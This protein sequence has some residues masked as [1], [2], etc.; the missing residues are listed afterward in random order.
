MAKLDEF[1]LSNKQ[2]KEIDAD[3]ADGKISH[4][5]ISEKLG[6]W[7]FDWSE[8]SVRR[9]RN[10]LGVK[11]ES[12]ESNFDIPP[13][14]DWEKA[15]IEVGPD[16]GVISTGVLN[17][18]ISL[19]ND[20]DGV[21]RGFGLDPELFEVA[22]DTVRMSKWQSSKRLDNGDRDIVWLYSY[23]AQFR[24]KS[25]QF[26]APD[27][28]FIHKQI[29]KWK[30][31]KKIQSK[32]IEEPCTFLIN[33]A[34]WQIGKSAGG[35]VEATVAKIEESF[36]L[37]LN[38]IDR[39][40]K[41][42]RNIESVAIFNM[43][44][45]TEGC[46]G[47]YSSQLFTVELNQR[48]QL[49]LVL[50]LW[51]K[52]LMTLQPDVF[53]SVLCNHGEW[54]RRGGSKPVTS[55]SDNAGGYLADTLYRVFE[56]KQGPSEWHIAHDEMIQMVNLSGI[57][58]AM[59]HGHK[60]TSK[61]KEAE[62]LRGQSIRLLKTHGVEPDVWFT[63]HL[64]HVS[65]EDHGPWWR[66][67]CPSLDGGSKWYTDFSGNWSTPGTLT[68]LIGKHDVRGWSDMSVLGTHEGHF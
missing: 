9:Y 34:D 62:W 24:R 61:A 12:N 38:E 43:G 31:T 59:T 18:P 54:T 66:F 28:D 29:A 63:A 16:G 53:A 13:H 7:G 10:N 36:Q 39:L 26:D 42:G 4:V 32:S 52:G 25:A 60:I 37:C 33:W 19:S 65:V 64:H 8:T 40:K 1:N 44:D 35:G 27:L 57:N 55:D 56:G 46:D 48:E 17:K 47:N 41:N 15:E 30:P 45:P 20:W 49:N 58:V 67:Q 50:D 5:T 2:R 14:L 23:K 51:T 22:N 3:L 21:L 68:M 6:D 11:L